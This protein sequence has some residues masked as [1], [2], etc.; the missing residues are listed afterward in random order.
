MWSYRRAICS[1]TCGTPPPSWSGARSLDRPTAAPGVLAP[2]H[3]RDDMRP[4]L[5]Y[6][7]AISLVL[8]PTQLSLPPQYPSLPQVRPICRSACKQHRSLFADH[9]STAHIGMAMLFSWG[10]VT[11]DRVLVSP[12]CAGSILRVDSQVFFANPASSKNRVNGVV[13]LLRH[14]RSVAAAV[15]V[16]GAAPTPTRSS[17]FDETPRS[18]QGTQRTAWRWVRGR[19]RW[20]AC[21]HRAD[22]RS[23]GARTA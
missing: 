15:C 16:P 7:H 2:R 21:K 10:P 20:P 23:A 3:Q 6:P 19:L 1:P 22:R 17:A 8:L 5:M 9:A 4:C 13:R 14:R 18:E 12:V 11:F